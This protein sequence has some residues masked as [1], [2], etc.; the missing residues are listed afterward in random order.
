MEMIEHILLFSLKLRNG[1]LDKF[2]S[3][4]CRCKAAKGLIVSENVDHVGGIF[5]LVVVSVNSGKELWSARDTA[6]VSFNPQHAAFNMLGP[7]NPQL[8]ACNTLHACCGKVRLVRV[9]T[10]TAGSWVQVEGMTILDVQPVPSDQ[11]VVFSNMPSIAHH[12]SVYVLASSIP[13]ENLASFSTSGGGGSNSS[14]GLA[15]YANHRGFVDSTFLSWGADFF[16][17]ERTNRNTL[18]LH[19][20]PAASGSPFNTV[21]VTV[22]QGPPLW[23]PK[24]VPGGSGWSLVFDQLP[25]LQIGSTLTVI[26]TVASGTDVTDAVA[27]ATYASNNPSSVIRFS[28]PWA[29]WVDTFGSNTIDS[30]EGITTL[31]TTLDRW[32]IA[33]CSSTSSPGL[34]Y[35]TSASSAWSDLQLDID[36][37]QTTLHQPVGV[38]A[39]VNEPN[40]P[41]LFV[42]DRSLDRIISVDMTNMSPLQVPA[43]T[44]SVVNTDDISLTLSNP[45]AIALGQNGTLYVVDTDNHRIVRIQQITTST[46]S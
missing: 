2:A 33:A 46:Y 1:Q 30:P 11:V 28:V 27:F 22:D 34:K 38:V 21:I 4:D 10:P 43:T 19:D 9:I 23:E 29:T 35:T 14:N 20:A 32:K 40:S 25:Q 3:F 26:A 24:S 18:T 6:F 41:K 12:A 17:M 42:L 15:F 16:T 7:F 5:H 37:G 8:A 44:L 39:C 13:P 31:D 45:G 36:G